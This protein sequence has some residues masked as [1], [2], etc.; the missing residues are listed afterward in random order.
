MVK[1]VTVSAVTADVTTLTTSMSGQ[2]D[3]VGGNVL[4]LNFLLY[5]QHTRVSSFNY[6]HAEYIYS[7]NDSFC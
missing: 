3:S 6:N 4:L 7:Q 5:T 1:Y 2:T